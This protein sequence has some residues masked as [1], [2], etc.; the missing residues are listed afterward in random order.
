MPLDSRALS[1]G[2]SRGSG[3]HT[4]LAVP[5]FPVFTYELACQ[6]EM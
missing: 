6:E 1:F 5:F 3:L 4:A 2:D